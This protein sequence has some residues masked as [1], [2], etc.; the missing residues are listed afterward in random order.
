MR[1]STTVA[2]HRHEVG[3][4]VVH[5]G[6]LIGVRHAQR[7][8]VLVPQDQSFEVAVLQEPLRGRRYVTPAEVRAVQLARQPGVVHA[9]HPGAIRL[10]PP[11]GL[12]GVQDGGV[13]PAAQHERQLPGQIVHAVVSEVHAEAA[14]GHQDV[15]CVA[16][17]E[18]P[19]GAEGI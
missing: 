4:L 15:R 7:R 19:P 9:G 6:R 11:L 13:G 12:V 14:G 8:R 2:H 18:Y 3:D 16:G 1:G 17:Q 10:L 5:D